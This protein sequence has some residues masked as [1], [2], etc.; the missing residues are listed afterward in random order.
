M[1]R[2]KRGI[3]KNKA[4]RST[5]SKTKG[6]RGAARHKK[7]AAYTSLYHA[8]TYAFA[9]RRDKKN[10]MRRLWTVRIN[11]ALMP[12]GISYSKFIKLLKN[13]NIGLDRK[14]LAEIAAAS[15]EAFE[16]IV[17]EVK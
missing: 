7:R 16:R 12:H 11:A 17:N 6:F 3:I 9:H 2:V 5:L 15:P 14:I 10:D 13:K 8:G 4:R 1:A